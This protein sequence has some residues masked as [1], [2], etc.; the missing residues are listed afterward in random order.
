MMQEGR[1]SI[2]AFLDE[3]RAKIPVPVI[4]ESGDHVASRLL[5]PE[6]NTRVIKILGKKR[7][8]G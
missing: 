4:W 3:V 5:T 8:V 7:K 1:Q 6:E 2:Q